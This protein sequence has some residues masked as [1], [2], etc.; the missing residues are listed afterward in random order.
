MLQEGVRGT[1][2]AVGARASIHEV[3][4]FHRG[5]RVK[6]VPAGGCPLDGRYLLVDGAWAQQRASWGGLSASPR[7]LEFWGDAPGSWGS[8]HCPGHTC[9]LSTWAWGSSQGTGLTQKAG[10]G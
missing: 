3:L 1:G 6:A 8:I 5:M 10:R 7:G 4:G 2:F 9:P